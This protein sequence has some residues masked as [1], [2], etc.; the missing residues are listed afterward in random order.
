MNRVEIF[1]E[2]VPL[3]RTYGRLILKVRSFVYKLLSFAN[4]GPYVYKTLNG[5]ILFASYR[6]IDYRYL[7]PFQPLLYLVYPFP[8]L[9]VERA[10]CTFIICHF[11][12]YDSFVL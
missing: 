11:S 2:N 7:W 10:F 3:K 12:M 6:P 4:K 9:R 1:I 8:F 5:K